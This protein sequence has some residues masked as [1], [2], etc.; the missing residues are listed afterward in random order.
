MLGWIGTEKRLEYTAISDS[1]NTCKRIQ[2]NAARNQILIS[3][4]AYERVK[5]EIEAKPFLPLSVKGKTQPLEVY[6]VLGLK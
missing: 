3:R 6:E 5:D 4:D 2:E 1:V